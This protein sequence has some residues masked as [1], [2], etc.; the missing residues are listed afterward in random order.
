MVRSPKRVNGR[1]PHSG[2]ANMPETL[3]AQA[4]PLM[5]MQPMFRD[6]EAK[7]ARWRA[8]TRGAEG[9]SPATWPG[10]GRPGR[11][12]GGAGH[13]RRAHGRP[14]RRGRGH[15]D[16]LRPPTRTRP[17]QGP[18]PPGRSRP[19]AAL[20]RPNPHRCRGRNGRP[21]GGRMRRARRVVHTAQPTRAPCAD[22]RSPARWLL[23][24]R[25]FPA[26]R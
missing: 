9:P 18:Q 17:R 13:G 22:T 5:I 12:R 25:S 4:V 6:R 21:H 19:P 2:Q 7:V 24:R 15:G 16:R 10:G 23:P 11:L 20:M 26:A 1:T 14:G 3:A 8:G